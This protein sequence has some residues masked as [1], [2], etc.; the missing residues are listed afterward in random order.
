MF[1]YGERLAMANEPGHTG[2]RTGLSD[3]S[4]LGLPV[5]HDQLWPIAAENALAVWRNDHPIHTFPTAGQQ[6][7]DTI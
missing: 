5:R 7:R 3:L 6:F 1:P 4:A 2:G